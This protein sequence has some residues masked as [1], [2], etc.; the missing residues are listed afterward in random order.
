LKLYFDAACPLCN[1]FAKLLR[2][3]LSEQVELL[4]MPQG[5]QAKDFKLELE[6]GEFLYGQEA[7]GALEKEIPKAKDFFWMLPDSYKG[8]ALHGAYALG[9]FWRRIFYFFRKRRCDECGHKE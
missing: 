8:K 4:E 6:G 9:K 2:K 1:S 5:E 7:I 3:H